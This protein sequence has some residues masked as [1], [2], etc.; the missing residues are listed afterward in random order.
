[1]KLRFKTVLAA[2]GMAVAVPAT[3][4]ADLSKIET[5]QEI[6]QTIKG[7]HLTLFA[8]KQNVSPE[9]QIAGRAYGRDVKGQWQWQN[10]YF[11]RDLYWGKMDLGPNC[12][13]VRVSG[14]TIRFTSD[15]GTGRY[16]DLR[17][18]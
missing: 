4:F 10:G 5:R 16:A 8:I 17:L 2:L 6:V 12:Q 13:E 1:M 3:A 18:R 15:R 9:G 7:K 11:C 14:D